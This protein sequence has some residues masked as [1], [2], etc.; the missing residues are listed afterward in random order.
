VNT[1]SVAQSRVEVESSSNA[2][3]SR[4]IR[5][6]LPRYG[7]LNK[8]YLHT[9]FGPAA[10]TF[11]TTHYAQAVP[12]IGAMCIRE[13]RLTYNGQTLQ[14]TNGHTIVADLWKHSTPREKKHLQEML[15]AYD[16]P[17]GTTLSAATG[18]KHS[19]PADI[20]RRM[21]AKATGPSN[22]IQDFYAPL[23]F[24]FDAKHSPNRALDLSVLSSPVILEIDMESQSNCFVANN[25]A[26]TALPTL[27]NV[28]ALCYLS[29]MDAEVEKSYRALTYQNGGSPMTQLS[30]NT[31]HIVVASNITLGTA[32]VA[33]DVK[34]NQFTGS[35]YKLVVFCTRTGAFSSAKPFR[36]QPGAIAEV[37]LKATGTNIVNQSKLQSK[38]SIL[39]SYH[40]GGEFYPAN[41]AASAWW[42]TITCNPNNFVELNFKK[43]Y[44]MSKV[45]ASG[46]VAFGALS[47]PSL[48]VLLGGTTDTGG[49]FGGQGIVLG[50]ASDIHVIAYTTSLMSYQTNAS[51][52]T[53]IRM[54]QN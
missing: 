40:S 17:A 42:S 53:N 34:L 12:F 6:E 16:A 26:I 18:E 49:Q 31:E 23:Q 44:D 28:S 46:S 21:I 11:S 2:G 8:L 54:I 5:V 4:T 1:E 25:S 15:G 9:R 50:E 47:V 36:I 33:V 35:V 22:G 41:N 39:E 13:A 19:T 27:D 20:A 51:G 30:F 52:S 38:E 43:P 29:E 24:Y 32:D 3:F 10:G 45:S 48:R 7:L 14:K 37:Q